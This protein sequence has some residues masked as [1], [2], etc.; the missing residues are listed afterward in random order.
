MPDYALFE[1][2]IPKKWP[3]LTRSLSGNRASMLVWQRHLPKLNHERADRSEQQR[4]I[5]RVSKG[6]LLAAWFLV[7]MLGS[8]H[9]DKSTLRANRLYVTGRC[10]HRVSPSFLTS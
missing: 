9:R 7:I 6:L 5:R 3:P 10:T 8:H 1:S 4:K 2:R